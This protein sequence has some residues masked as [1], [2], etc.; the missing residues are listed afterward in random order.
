MDYEILAKYL[1]TSYFLYIFQ[2]RQSWNINLS[3]SFGGFLECQ[4]GVVVQS[5][6]ENLIGCTLTNKRCVCCDPNGVDFQ[7]TSNI[8]N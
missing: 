7:I 6:C 1:L 3:G 2:G 8:V 4:L 5:E